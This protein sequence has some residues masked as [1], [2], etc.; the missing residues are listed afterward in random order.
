MTG[1]HHCQGCR[2]FL[3]LCSYYCRF[4]KDFAE[5]AS[6]LHA[7]TGKYVRFQW[8]DECQMAFDRLK[9]A[10]T[11]SPILAMPADGHVYVLD[12]DAVN[13]PLAPYCPRSK[14]GRRR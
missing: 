9:A 5:V 6:P 3:G 7:L 2:G 12:T 11:S 4:V 1:P 8:N 14:E 13:S 10:L